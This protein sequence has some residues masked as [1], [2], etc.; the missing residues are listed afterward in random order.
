MYIG[1]GLSSH[2]SLHVWSDAIV[3]VRSGG[4]RRDSRIWVWYSPINLFFSVE[5]V[6][7]EMDVLKQRKIDGERRVFHDKWTD[8]YFFITQK[9]N[10]VYLVCSETVEVAKPHTPAKQCMP[11][12]P[13]PHV[14]FTLQ[15]IRI[16]SRR[17][18]R[19]NVPWNGT[20]YLRMEIT[21]SIPPENRIVKDM[22]CQT[23]HWLRVS[24]WE[25]PLIH[26][27]SSSLQRTP[28]Y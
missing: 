9:G 14:A 4:F 10:P 27:T 8:Q 7:F 23:S 24:H 21:P 11:N 22:K 1:R 5:R 12:R 25:L 26:L 16:R 19:R 15:S 18:R 3:V 6:E 28:T 13:T 20:I 2:R 17:K